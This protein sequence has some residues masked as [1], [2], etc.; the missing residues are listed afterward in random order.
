MDNGENQKILSRFQDINFKMTT[1][2][3]RAF[4]IQTFR[5]PEL[6]AFA[7]FRLPNRILR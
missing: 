2:I 1:F 3:P 7:S 4:S 6:N 5:L